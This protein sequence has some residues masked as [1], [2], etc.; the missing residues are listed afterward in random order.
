MYFCWVKSFIFLIGL[1]LS[2][3]RVCLK[4]KD[5]GDTI[6]IICRVDRLRYGIVFENPAGEE[7]GNCEAPFRFGIERAFCNGKFN[8]HQDLATNTTTLTIK[9][10]ELIYGEWKCYHGIHIGSDSVDIKMPGKYWK[11]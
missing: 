3:H 9:K 8:I 1:S 5:M 2:H 6:E 10:S 11:T 4:Y 7:N